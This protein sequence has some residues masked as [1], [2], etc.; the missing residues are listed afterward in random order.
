MLADLVRGEERTVASV[1]VVPEWLVP[2]LGQCDPPLPT[3]SIPVGVGHITTVAISPGERRCACDGLL[4]P[5]GPSEA[6]GVGQ[7]TAVRRS[8]GLPFG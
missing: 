8:D 3:A 5:F 6:F 2:R 7:S 1:S 4:R